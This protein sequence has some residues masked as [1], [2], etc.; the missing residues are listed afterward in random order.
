M[1]ATRKTI[2][3]AMM[4]LAMA[5][6]VL[7]AACSATPNLDTTNKRVYATELAVQGMLDQVD[8]YQQEGR[9]T[10]EEWATV[11]GQLER[12][13]TAYEAMEL[14]HILGEDPGADIATVHSVLLTLRQQMEGR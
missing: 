10:D 9:F 12:L 5:A 6:A 2:R 7:L 8:Q 11:Q 14:T 4:A 3:W 1:L 13:R